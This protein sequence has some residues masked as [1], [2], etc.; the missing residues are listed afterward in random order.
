M[1]GRRDTVGGRR[2]SRWRVYISAG[3]CL[4]RVL[5]RTEFGRI[6][7]PRSQWVW[8]AACC[9]RC[10]LCRCQR[11]GLVLERRRWPTQS[12]NAN[13]GLVY[14]RRSNHPIAQ[15]WY[16]NK[17]YPSVSRH[18]PMDNFKYYQVCNASLVHDVGNVQYSNRCRFKLVQLLVQMTALEAVPGSMWTPTLFL[19]AFHLVHALSLPFTAAS[20]L[21]CPRSFDLMPVR[22]L[23][24]GYSQQCF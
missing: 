7:G 10:A 22:S 21:V 16:V 17:Y 12:T 11:A 19:L 9:E 1:K 13:Q 3:G 4:G 8:K 15:P 6:V 5:G 24:P 2:E 14:V 18:S 23:L 20:G